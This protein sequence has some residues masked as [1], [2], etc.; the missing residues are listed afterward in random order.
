[1][2]KKK[3][4]KVIKKLQKEITELNTVIDM[5][6]D[7]INESSIEEAE[8][9]VKYEKTIKK[10]QKENAQLEEMQ[11]DFK[12]F[13]DDAI[14]EAKKLKEQNQQI[15]NDLYDITIDKYELKI[16]NKILE[17]SLHSCENALNEKEII[18]TYLETRGDR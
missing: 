7:L 5:S 6:R 14:A 9:N 2:T 15:S 1:M 10:L 17:Q 16:E 18:I 3:M 8:K 13:F 4:K 11:K 12:S